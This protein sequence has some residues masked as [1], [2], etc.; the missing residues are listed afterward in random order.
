[1]NRVLGASQCE[2]TQLR[3]C[4]TIPLCHIPSRRFG[5]PRAQALLGNASHLGLFFCFESLVGFCCMFSRRFGGPRAQALLS[6]AS[7][8][9]L[10]LF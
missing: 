9:G 1:M 5:G 4:A 8:L 10:F 3:A 7:H 2:N 6:N